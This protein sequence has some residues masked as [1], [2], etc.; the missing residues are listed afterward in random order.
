MA[1][2]KLTEVAGLVAQAVM[3]AKV[4]DKDGNAKTVK[5]TGD[6]NLLDLTDIVAGGSTGGNTGGGTD[7]NHPTAGADYYAGSL[8][9]GEITER[10]L[11][12][13]RDESVAE[14]TAS[15]TVTL[16]RDV[17]SKFNMVGDGATF[18]VHLQRTAMAKGAKGAVTDIE[19]NYD[20]NNAAK[21]GYFTTTSPYPIYIKS[22]DLATK[23]TLAIPINGIGESLSGKNVKAPQLNVTFNDNGTMTFESVTGY[24]ND[25]NS[26]GAT[27]ANYEVIVDVIATFST[28]PAVAQLPPSVNLFSGSASG[29]ITLTGPSNYFENVMDGIEITFEQYAIVDRAITDAFDA[30]GN[31]N[32]K[33]RFD[34]SKLGIG[35]IR[36]AKEDLIIGNKINFL[37]Q[38]KFLSTVSGFEYYDNG[39]DRWKSYDPQQTI[40]FDSFD[41]TIMTIK[42]NGVINLGLN[43]I[44]SEDDSGVVGTAKTPFKLNVSKVTTYKD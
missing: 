33:Y 44:L 16:L 10:Y 24:D 18:L 34:V 1:T 11:L 27:G 19:L 7:P 17:G 30:P 39:D 40:K 8:A 13:Q 20:S 25:G 4:K 32:F 36:L 42:Q 2:N 22:A 29:D 9:D 12:Y 43:I 3:G 26:A 23:K 14:T 15:K 41:N 28:Q 5:P 31:H 35:T 37:S 21:N 6:D 38:L